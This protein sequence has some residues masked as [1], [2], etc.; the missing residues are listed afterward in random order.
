MDTDRVNRKWW[1]LLGISIG[2]FMAALDESAIS[3]ILPIMNH[4]FASSISTIGWVAT[5]YLLMISGLLLSFGRLGDLRGHKR[6]YIFGLAIFILGSA[7]CGLAPTV[8]AM[9]VF[10]A[11]QGFGAAMLL[12]NALALLT[13]NFPSNQRGQV[14][15]LLATITY[16]GTMMGPS[17]GGYL[18]NQFSWR[19]VFYINIL[20]GLLALWLSLSF[21]PRDPTAEKKVPFDL[22]GAITFT[23]GLVTLLLGLNQGQAWGW[24][25]LGVFVLLVTAVLLLGA[26]IM[27][28]RYVSY[29]MLDLSLFQ[30]RLFTTAAISSTLNYFCLSSILFLLPFYLIQGRGFS[31]DRAG[32]LF[33][34]LP[35]TMAIVAPLSGR[36][37]DIIGSRLLATLGMTILTVGL[38]LL[39]CLGSQSSLSSVVAVLLTIGLGI[40]LFASPNNSTLMGSAPHHQQGI[41][42]GIL[43]T[44]RNIGMVLGFAV[45]SAIL[46]TIFANGKGINLF[47]AIHACFLVSTGAA[48]LGIFTSVIRK[49]KLS[50]GVE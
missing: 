38:F 10:R 30:Q 6:V 46:S 11:L 5:I 48:T 8:A 1:I 3:A 9:I 20:P 18:T 13:R 15:G 40:G 31:P 2:C 32:L 34:T 29:P 33:T 24:T 36:L 26:F 41:A 14:L 39:S 43:A 4:A 17:L 16:I 7:L 21:I 35:L 12:A 25:S 49:T 22:A 47:D 23:L 27:V 50:D 44:A 37:S 28:E 19:S 42:G 45:Q